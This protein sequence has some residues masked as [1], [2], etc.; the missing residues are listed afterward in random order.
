[1]TQRRA[2]RPRALR[3]SAAAVADLETFLDS[4]DAMSSERSL[5]FESELRAG[6][7]PLRQFPE[8]GRVPRDYDWR[9]AGFE[10]LRE[11]LVWDYRVGYL[12]AHQAVEIVYLVH[13]KRRVPPLR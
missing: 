13:G 11:V 5:T 2:P 3:W 10:N 4:L 12:V 8:M 1:M 7:A 6:L 9:S